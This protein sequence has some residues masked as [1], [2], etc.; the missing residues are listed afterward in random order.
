MNACITELKIR[1]RLGLNA[2]HAGDTALLDRARAVSG[3]SMPEQTPW[4]LRHTLSLAARSVG[5]RTWDQ[6]RNV[7]G[8]QASPGDDMGAFWHSPR[9]ES[10]LNHWFADV[11]AAR[12]LLLKR[13]SLILLP[14]RKQFVVVDSPYLIALG[15]DPDAWANEGCLDMVQAYGSPAWLARCEA[16]LRAPEAHWVRQR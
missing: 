7:L 1:A 8:G 12:V 10:L 15:M 9:C 5:F 16:R 4:K 3:L 11:E 14:Y 13:P 2:L 6:A